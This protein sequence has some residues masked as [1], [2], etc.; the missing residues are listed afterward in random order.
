MLSVSTEATGMLER[1]F[2]IYWWLL[3]VVIIVYEI[4]YWQPKISVM[5]YLAFLIHIIEK[6]SLND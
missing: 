4:T 5:I 1:R 3:V 6:V 2:K